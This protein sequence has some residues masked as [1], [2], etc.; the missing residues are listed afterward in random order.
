VFLRLTLSVQRILRQI[1]W[2]VVLISF[3]LR[4]YGQ[5]PQ[6]SIQQPLWSHDSAK[7]KRRNRTKL[8]WA[9]STGDQPWPDQQCKNQQPSTTMKNRPSRIIKN[10]QQPS[11]TIKNHQ[12]SSIIIN[13][14]QQSTNL[15]HEGVSVIAQVSL[16]ASQW[17]ICAEPWC[18]S[19]LGQMLTDWKKTC[20]TNLSD[21]LTKVR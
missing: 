18:G 21:C 1:C 19:W 7:S 13:H 11:T 15:S 6:L 12:W 16:G 17:A 20:S 10:H 2:A 9:F 5:V 4:P 3:D 14:H 8:L